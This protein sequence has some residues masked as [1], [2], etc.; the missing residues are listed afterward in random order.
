MKFKEKF[1]VSKEFEDVFSFDNNHEKLE[2]EA[3][4]IM[5]RFLSEL[6]KFY[7]DKPIKK[8]E[9]AEALQTSPSFITQLFRGDKLINLLT[10]AKI[11]EAFN[12]QFQITAIPA[13]SKKVNKTPVVKSK[14]PR[15]LPLKKK[16]KSLKS[17]T[18]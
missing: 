8:K 2:H 6:Q 11:Q 10:I 16:I 5:F 18:T 7:G 9:L 15:K 3:K 4:M 12:I 13:T 14:I 1:E 17:I